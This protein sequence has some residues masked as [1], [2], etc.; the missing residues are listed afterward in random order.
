MDDHYLYTPDDIAG[1]E[2]GLMTLNQGYLLATRDLLGHQ[3]KDIIV[4][5]LTYGMFRAGIDTPRGQAIAQ[6]IGQFKVS[7]ATTD[8]YVHLTR[9]Q[10]ATMLLSAFSEPLDTTSPPVL[11]DETGSDRGVM[12]TLRVKYGFEWKD[13]FGAR[14]FQPDKIVSIGEALALANVYISK[15]V[16]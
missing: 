3:A 4:R 10:F 6:I 13:Q 8:D 14:Y 1:L 9:G 12:T 11:I 15:K 7:S 5:S 2:K 16:Q